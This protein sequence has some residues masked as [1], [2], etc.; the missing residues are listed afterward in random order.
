MVTYVVFVWINHHLVH[1]FFFFCFVLFM[2]EVYDIID[3]KYDI[4]F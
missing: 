4:I 2:L 3:E 1:P